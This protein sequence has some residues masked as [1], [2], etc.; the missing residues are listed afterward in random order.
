MAND[1]DQTSQQGR[2]AHDHP[3]GFEND[4][5]RPFEP[6]QRGGQMSGGQPEMD[7]QRESQG[8]GQGVG[9]SA[10]QGGTG[11]HATGS[12]ADNVQ[13]DIDEASQAVLDEDNGMTENNR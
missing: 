3:G 4:P 9:G 1:Q 7:R 6:G 10:H 11:G 5:Q 12:K 8:G 2:T 13:S